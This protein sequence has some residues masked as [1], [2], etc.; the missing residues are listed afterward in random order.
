MK[1]PKLTKEGKLP[2]LHDVRARLY[3]ND[4]MQLFLERLNNHT[5][6][7]VCKYIAGYFYRQQINNFN[8]L[9]ERADRIEKLETALKFLIRNEEVNEA[10]AKTAGEP[11]VNGGLDFARTL[12][13]MEKKDGLP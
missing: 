7:E 12:L 3:A 13:G 2:Q 9:K 8:K 11:Y 10:L 6:S 1:E 5:L 4:I